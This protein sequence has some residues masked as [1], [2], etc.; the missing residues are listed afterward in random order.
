MTNYITL[1]MG[2]TVEGLISYYY[3]N[4]N[5][6]SKFKTG[7]TIL[8]CL[9][10]NYAAFILNIPFK[11]NPYINLISFFVVSFLYAF[12]C[13]DITFKSCLFHS[14]IVTIAMIG[15]EMI[16]EVVISVFFKEY[17]L[18]LSSGTLQFFIFFAISK[19]FLLIVLTFV[20]KLFS[21]KKNNALGDMRN[22]Y[23]SFLYPVTIT[24]FLI[25]YFDISTHYKLSDGLRFSIIVLSA[26]S[27]LI[28]CFVVVYNQRIQKRENEIAEL[29]RESFKNEIDMQ[30]LDLLEKKN[31]EMQILTH[32]Y[33]N[34]LSAIRGLSS[35]GEVNEYIDSITSEISFADSTCQSGNHT[36]DV[37]I[38]KYVTECMIKGVSFDYE[39]K[40][41]NLSS[42]NDYDLVTILGNLLDNALE[43]AQN[44]A[45][46]SITLKTN[47]INT[48]DSIVVI[49]SSDTPPEKNLK[50]TKQNKKLHGVGLK[51]VTK[52]LKKYGGELEWE[53]NNDTKEFITTVILLTDSKPSP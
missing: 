17:A 49:N 26:S 36:L 7:R 46:K 18:V 9:L 20:A 48:Y 31:Q 4:E 11:V 35:S 41:S 44:S 19:S 5:Y 21:Y 37:I 12:L 3:F 1:F 53:Y 14:S 2:Y 10:F 40:L 29:E 33:K 13:F 24:A 51:S 32:D 50:T 28:S 23:L 43:A 8:Y 22:T 25:F 15:T 38:N 39:I 47:K 52:T 42:V 27:L 45:K 34:H 6:S 16:M 30:Y